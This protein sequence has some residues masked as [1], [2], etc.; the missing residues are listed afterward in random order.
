MD[1]SNI[2]KKPFQFIALIAFFVGF[3]L[4]S[5]IYLK[6][7][8]EY[9]VGIIQE[10]QIKD[11]TNLETVTLGD[12]LLMETFNEKVMLLCMHD[13]QSDIEDFLVLYR[14]SQHQF[15]DRNDLYLV[16]YSNGFDEQ[17]DEAIHGLRR[18]QEVFVI[19]TSETLAEV[20][21]SMRVP[22]DK[23][24]VLLD[25]KL[26]I[27]NYYDIK[28]KDDLAQLGSHI[29]KVFPREKTPEFDYIPQTEK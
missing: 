6:N 18:P 26:Y 23:N 11:S 8:F 3:P 13:Q 14:E 22:D 28:D 27:R 9:Q 19:E 29:V 24:L 16:I 25:P 20:K 21:Q 12:S 4:I 2:K 7:G 1:L 10:V 17:L 15:G 5:Y